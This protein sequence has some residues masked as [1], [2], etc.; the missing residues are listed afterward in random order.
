[1]H[2]QTFRAGRWP[3][4]LLAVIALALGACSATATGTISGSAQAPTPASSAAAAADPNGVKIA[5]FA[6]TPGTLTVKVGSTVTWTNSD[7]A[8]HTVT[9]D[10]G[11]FDSKSIAPG[12]AFSHLMDK[13]G[14]YAYHCAI[15]SSMTATVIVK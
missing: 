2:L 6:F 1:M 15:H 10:D 4:A 14:T 13:A 8:A 12:G 3:L 11:S 9:A 7:S 5:D